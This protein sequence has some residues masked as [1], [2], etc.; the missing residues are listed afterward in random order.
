MVWWPGDGTHSFLMATETRGVLSEADE[1]GAGGGHYGH[2]L[3]LVER[4]K[5]A[6][7]L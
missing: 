5:H 1:G 4:E 3:I 2:I 7:T 6:F